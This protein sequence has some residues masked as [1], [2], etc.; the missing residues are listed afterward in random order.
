MD[1]E[2]VLYI[3]NGILLSHKKEWELPFTIIWVDLESMKWWNKTKRKTNTLYYHFYV[4]SKKKKKK[5]TINECI[6]QNGNWPTDIE[7]KLGLSVG[8][9][10]EKGMR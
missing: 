4:E 2:G 8:R 3:F 10:N 1:T 9:K 6:L 5:K 7:N